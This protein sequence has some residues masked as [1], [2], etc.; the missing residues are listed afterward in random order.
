MI[1]VKQANAVSAYNVLKQIKTKELPA[2]VAI[3]IWKNVKNL[4]ATAT[5]YEEAI[6]DA[7]E[8]LKGENDDEMNKLL[9]ELQK[10]ETDEA[11]GKYTFT[12]TDNENR[13]KVTEYY[14]NAQ[15][16]LN[17]FIKDLDNKEVEVEVVTLSED[18][19]IKSL[20]GTDFNIGIIELISFLFEDNPFD[21]DKA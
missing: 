3:V 21:T 12:R 7:K 1:K 17:K 2:E 10:K 16:K 9:E 19:L 5:S 4:K 8:S 15:I 11:A 18:D 20:I 13:A 14:Q 6:K